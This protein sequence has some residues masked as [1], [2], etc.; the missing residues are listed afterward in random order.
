VDIGQNTRLTLCHGFV[1]LMVC[2][3]VTLSLEYVNSWVYRNHLHTPR[4]ARY[5]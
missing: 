3:T 4:R 1:T 5:P 2:N